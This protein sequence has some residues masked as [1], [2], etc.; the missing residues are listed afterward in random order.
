MPV[1]VGGDWP[2][3]P[4]GPKSDRCA[5]HNTPALNATFC[6]KADLESAR[7]A[8]KIAIL[9]VIRALQTIYF[10]QNTSLVPWT[11]IAA[12]KAID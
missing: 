8:A 5:V 4:W 10:E 3:C 11:Q 12:Q 6:R 9:R 7:Q 2:W 1:G